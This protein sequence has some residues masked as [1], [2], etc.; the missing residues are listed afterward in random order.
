MSSIHCRIQNLSFGKLL[1][2]E[3]EER[4]EGPLIVKRRGANVV[5]KGMVVVKKGVNVV[6]KGVNVVK[7]GERAMTKKNSNQL[8]QDSKMAHESTATMQEDNPPMQKN[9]KRDHP[10]PSSSSGKRNDT[11]AAKGLQLFSY[12]DSEYC[13]YCEM[14]MGNCIAEVVLLHPPLP[15]PFPMMTPLR[16]P[17]NHTMNYHRP[18]NSII[19]YPTHTQF[20]YFVPFPVGVVSLICNRNM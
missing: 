4:K 2:K 12:A 15:K 1:P 8:S 16:S 13:V 7:K 11:H 18:T 20:P 14:M 9:E 10:D 5:K 19:L 17:F 3:K 6:K